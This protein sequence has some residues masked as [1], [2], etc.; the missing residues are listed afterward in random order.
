M[1]AP[2]TAPVNV[3][4][5]AVAVLA[6]A[7]AGCLGGAHVG[8]SGH[9]YDGYGHDKWG[10]RPSKH[11]AGLLPALPVVPAL[12]GAQDA[13]ATQPMRDA[14]SPAAGLRDAVPSLDGIGLMSAAQPAGVTGMTSGSLL[15]LVVGAMAAASA[16]L[17]ATTRRV[18]FGKHKA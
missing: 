11:T 9:G 1:V 10:K 17:F 16:T 3:C 8:K 14:S 13:G 12:N 5:N 2:I 7:A 4:G 18:R 15:A 6:D